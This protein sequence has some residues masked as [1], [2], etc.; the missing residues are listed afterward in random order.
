MTLLSVKGVNL[1]S[2]EGILA[3][4]LSTYVKETSA[5]LASELSQNDFADINSLSTQGNDALGKEALDLQTLNDN[6]IFSY[7][8]VLENIASEFSSSGNEIAKYTVQEGDT[9][10]FIASDYGVSINTIIWANNMKSAD[11]IKPG[12]ELKIPP[13][14]GVVHT[15]KSSDTLSTIA[16][17]YGVDKDKII[18]FNNLPQTGELQV[19]EDLIVPDGV[20]KSAPKVVAPAVAII[21]RFANLPVLSGFFGLPTASN[22]R[23]SQRLHGRN[24]VDLANY[25]GTPIYA[26]A[27]GTVNLAKNSGY[28]GGFGKF[29][30]ITHNNG[31]ETLYAH[32]SQVLVSVGQTVAKGQQIA[33][34]GSTGRSTGCHLH[35]EVHGAKN[36]FSAAKS[37]VFAELGSD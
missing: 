11:E 14:S 24:G 17:K 35:F 33:M 28:N 15:V 21:Q 13:V 5:A 23:L 10:S 1:N 34:M 26:A 32:A 6:S 31:T 4:F 8:S 7:S 20:I 22:Y 29:I 27:S 12:T 19:G 25:C 2:Q 16:T 3:N 36:P 37:Q 18:S 30:R 9:I